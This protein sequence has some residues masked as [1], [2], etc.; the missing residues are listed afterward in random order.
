M[1]ARQIIYHEL[2]QRHQDAVFG[3]ACRMLRN[4]ADAE[5]VTQEALLQ[6]WRRWGSFNP[7]KTRPWIMRVTHNLC[8]D[9]I[10]RRDR[11]SGREVPAEPAVLE[12]VPD[13]GESRDPARMADQ[14]MLRERIEAAIQTL[15]PTLRSVFVLRELQDLKCAQIADVLGMPES[16][17]KVYLFRARNHLQVEL[18]D[19]ACRA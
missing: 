19:D 11:A 17:V 9:V 1:S 6:M 12:A 5:D 2:V 10:R 4:R 13:A 18:R 16:T 8:V 14:S 3:Y 15:P 7:L